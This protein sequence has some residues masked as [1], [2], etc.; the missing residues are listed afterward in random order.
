[1]AKSVIMGINGLFSM[2]TTIVRGAC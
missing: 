2:S 1:L